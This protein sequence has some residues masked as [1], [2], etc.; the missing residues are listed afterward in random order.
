[1]LVLTYPSRNEK[2]MCPA[3]M[4]TKHYLRDE[5]DAFAKNFSLL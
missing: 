4:V 2:R 3:S 1:M 5:H